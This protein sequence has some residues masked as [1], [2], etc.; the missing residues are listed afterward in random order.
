MASS[1]VT[2]PVTD[3]S[4]KQNEEPNITAEDTAVKTADVTN[5]KRKIDND[6]EGG[7]DGKVYLTPS[8]QSRLHY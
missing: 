3:I 4:E 5:K 1:E 8:S 6:A 2:D 7:V